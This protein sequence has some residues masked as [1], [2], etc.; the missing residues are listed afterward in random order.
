MNIFKHCNKKPNT[1]ECEAA[2]TVASHEEA[3][4]KKQD[5]YNSFACDFDCGSV[6]KLTDPDKSALFFAFDN[7]YDGYKT[8]QNSTPQEID[9]S[10]SIKCDII[11]KHIDKYGYTVIALI[12]DIPCF[13][14]WDYMVDSYHSLYF[15]H[16]ENDIAA[17]YCQEGYQISELYVF[18]NI[19]ETDEQLKSILKDNDFPI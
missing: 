13:D 5:I 17:L 7:L 1:N 9:N 18:E 8:L 12:Q 6:I 11:R 3:E 15:F 19:R 4:A 10:C 14:S 16:N 2:L